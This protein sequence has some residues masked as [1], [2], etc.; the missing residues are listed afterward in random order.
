MIGIG[1]AVAI[2]I[3]ALGALLSIWV[4]RYKK[5]GPEEALIITGRRGRFR[6]VRNGGAF[7]LPFVEKVS[8]VPLTAMSVP[9]ETESIMSK[10][11]IP[12]TLAGQ[13]IFK[14]GDT[15]EMI[16]AAATRFKGEQAKEL[17]EQVRQMLEGHVRSI[18]GSMTPED[19]YRD[20]QGFLKRISEQSEPELRR[21]GL[22]LDVLTL[23]DVRDSVGYLGALGQSRTAEVKRDARM[24]QAEAERD[25]RIKEVTTKQDAETRT[26]ET[27]VAIANAQA[28]RDRKKADFRASVAAKEA[29]ADQAGPKASAQAQQEVVQQQTI[30]AT[31]HA[32]QTRQQLIADV[33]RPAEAA[34]EKVR[35]DAAA[36]KDAQ[37]ID[38]EARQIEFQKTGEGEAAKIRATGTAEADIVKAKLVAEADGISAKAKALKE[39]NES[40]MALDVVKLLISTLPAIVEAGTKATSSVESIKI[41]HFDGGNGAT[42][43]NGV[44]PVDRLLNVSP[45][46]LGRLNEVLLATVGVDL[47]GIVELVRTGKTGSLVD[48]L[49]PQAPR[50]VEN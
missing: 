31:R 12:L 43:A 20:R 48:A 46:A 21:L 30:L 2:A 40:G 27:E 7:V 47:K 39:Y 9:F 50:S 29:E 35:I 11:G 1:I 13:A 25:A 42:G 14:V 34:A 3:V 44:G 38:A 24:G 23:S 36:K 18:G 6:V 49:T 15:E 41:V 45:A 33:V 26:A 4:S 8:P 37:V 17:T 22:Q 5:V 10:E 16:V 32:E 28:D 19:I